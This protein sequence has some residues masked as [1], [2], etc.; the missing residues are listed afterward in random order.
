MADLVDTFGALLDAVVFAAQRVASQSAAARDLEA[1]ALIAA[2]GAIARARRDLDAS[3]SVIAG[4]IALRSRPEAGH[5]GL[6]QQEGFRTPEALVQHATGSTA[7]EAITLVRVGAMIHD[8]NADATAAL[9]HPVAQPWLVPVGL[10]VASGTLSVTAAEVI[11]NGL[12]EPNEVVSVEALRD[13][14]VALVRLGSGH[15][16]ESSLGVGSQLDPDQL[17]RRARDARDDLDEAGIAIR[18]RERRQQ[19]SLRRWRKPDGMTRYSWE[20]DPEGAALV[21]GIYDQ[22]TPPRRGG[23]RMVDKAEQKRAEAVERDPRTTDQLASDGFLELLTIAIGTD[24]RQLIGI[25]N[26]AIRVLVSAENLAGRSGHGRIEGHHDPISIETVE[27]IACNSGIVPIHFDSHGQAID[28]GRE[29][30]LFTRR[31]RIGLAARDGGCRWPGCERPPGWT[32]AHHVEHWKRDDGETNI[33]NGILL[34]RHHHLLLH[35]NRWEIAQRGAEY[36]LIPPP[37]IDPHRTARP[38]PS[39]SPALCDL[40]G[41]RSA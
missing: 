34:C 4:E 12:G 16:S 18:E 21:D 13:A 22:L 36:W 25:K 41:R 17:F 1:K 35:D 6:A 11:R 31:Q 8:S 20:L 37:E 40:L 33:D 39:K 3:A 30:R 15:D 27:R 7:R 29:Q 9:A 5:A 2:Q 24:P 19:R 14:A 10:A 23:P 26:P 38:M 28:V 32:E